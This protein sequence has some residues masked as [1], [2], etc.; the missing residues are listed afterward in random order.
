VFA[1]SLKEW[2]NNNGNHEGYWR[3]Q[4]VQKDVRNHVQ[5]CW[6]F[7]KCFIKPFRVCNVTNTY[8]SMMHLLNA[9]LHVC[10]RLVVTNEFHKPLNHAYPSL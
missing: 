1:R 7:I 5:T 6:K 2:K 10:K 9:H 8:G 4:I 3:C